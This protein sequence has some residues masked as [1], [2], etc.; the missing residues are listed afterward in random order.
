MFD[1]RPRASDFRW[2]YTARLSSCFNGIRKYATIEFK[3]EILRAL[4]SSRFRKR[5]GYE[6]ATVRARS[7]PGVRTVTLRNL[8]HNGEA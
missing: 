3:R 2:Q 4:G 8:A 5:D 6:R 1:R 7:D